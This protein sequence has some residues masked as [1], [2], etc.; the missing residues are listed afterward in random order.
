[1]SNKLRFI[2]FLSLFQ[3]INRR[4]CNFQLFSQISPRGK[5]LEKDVSIVYQINTVGIN[6]CLQLETKI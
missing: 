6:N 3:H 1:M 4:V 2:Q 5:C